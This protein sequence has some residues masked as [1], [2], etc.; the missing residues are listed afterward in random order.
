MLD[1]SVSRPNPS[2]TAQNNIIESSHKNIT[3]SNTY[4]VNM[5]CY[6]CS[7]AGVKRV[8]EYAGKG[9]N[10]LNFSPFSHKVFN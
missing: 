8:Q 10:F 2:K 3:I 1:Q 7:F 9:L 5:L 4:Y 6:L